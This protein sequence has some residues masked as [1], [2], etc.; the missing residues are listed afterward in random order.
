MGSLNDHCKSYIKKDLCEE[1]FYGVI[2]SQSEVKLGH[3]KAG[4]TCK[5]SLNLK[6]CFFI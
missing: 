1:F 4:Y 3:E 6:R 2:V 5:A